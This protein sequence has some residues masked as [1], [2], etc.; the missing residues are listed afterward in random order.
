MLL[1]RRG[2]FDGLLHDRALAANLENINRGHD[3]LCLVRADAD[4]FGLIE[5][6]DARGADVGSIGVEFEHLLAVEIRREAG[7]ADLDHDSMPLTEREIARQPVRE[8]VG[9]DATSST[10]EAAEHSIRRV[11]E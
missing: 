7:V 5:T 8:A 3:R 9:A 2:G 10:S 1:L 11:L 6:P 4:A